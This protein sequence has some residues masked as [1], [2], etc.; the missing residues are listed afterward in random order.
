MSIASNIEVAKNIAEEL[1]AVEKLNYLNKNWLANNDP[2]ASSRA[3][4]E[5]FRELIGLLE[6]AQHELASLGRRVSREVEVEASNMEKA[7]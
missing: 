4:Q 1:L 7:S 5:R 2:A 3:V 6:Y